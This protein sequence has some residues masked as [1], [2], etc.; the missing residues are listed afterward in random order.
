MAS[1]FRKK[2][3]EAWKL[4]QLLKS[5]VFHRKL[6][7]WGLLSVAEEIES[8]KG[9]E[10]EWN[11]D[12]LKISE[13][14]WNKVIHSGIKPVRVFAHPI[15]L[16]GNPRRLTYYRMLAMV[17]QK[18][19]GNVGLSV[20]RY[21]L[22]QKRLSLSNAEDFVGHLNVII[23]DLIG[24]DKVVNP[25]ELDMWR[26]MAA[27]SQ[28]QGSWLNEKGKE[29][30]NIINEI[31]ESRIQERDSGTLVS[32]EG[33]SKRYDLKDNR[34]LVIASE[35][36]IGIYD[37][38]GVILIA[39]EIKGGIDTAGVLER[40]GASLKSLS[41][42][43][44]ENEKSVTILILPTVAMTTAFLNEATASGFVDHYFPHD[45]IVEEQNQR[46]KFFKLLGI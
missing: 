22:G 41:R 32:Q 39:V 42:A 23:S 5:R 29:A 11:K 12:A 21:E 15:V 20:N 34:Q 1:L 30:A 7:E 6:H 19:M 38:S 46:E 33:D 45:E 25:R 17:S 36:D 18:S 26:A 13:K 8:V 24:L 35:P 2:E 9:E 16:L 4:D 43:K 3:K 31:V 40:L 27:G 28:A 37:T 44:R 10:L 14:A